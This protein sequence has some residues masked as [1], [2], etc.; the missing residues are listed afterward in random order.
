M[1]SKWAGSKDTNGSATGAAV[2]RVSTSLPIYEDTKLIV[3]K[4]I[5]MKWKEVNDAFAGTFGETSKTTSVNG[6]K[7]ATFRA[8]DYEQMYHMSKP[9]I[10]METPFNTPSSNANSIDILNN[11][12]KEPTKFRMTPNQV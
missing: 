12:V 11:W 1:A 4:D 5:K 7:F 2:E 3:D 6:T 8:Q 9:M 10:I